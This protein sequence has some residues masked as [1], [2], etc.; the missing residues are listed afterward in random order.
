M[1]KYTL[2]VL[3][4]VA[5]F[6]LAVSV[7]PANAGA[8]TLTYVAPGPTNGELDSMDAAGYATASVQW[9]PSIAYV[10]DTLITATVTWSDTGG[11]D[12]TSSQ[13]LNCSA[14]TIFGAEY[15][16]GSANQPGSDNIYYATF[17]FDTTGNTGADSICLRVPVADA[18]GEEQATANFSLTILVTGDSASGDFGGIEYYSNGG[19]D[20]NVHG[21]IGPTLEFAIVETGDLK[22][23][24]HD[25]QLGEDQSLTNMD[26]SVTNTCA[27]RIKVQTNATDGFIVYV[28]SD[29]PLD[30]SG[31]ATITDVTD[32]E[33]PD[34]STGEAYGFA[35]E[36]A[37]DGGRNPITGLFDQ[38]IVEHDAGT[39]FDF[40]ADYTPVPTNT[41]PQMFSFTD[42]FV[43]SSTSAFTATSLITHAATITPTT[44]SG[45]YDQLVTYTVTPSF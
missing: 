10:T 15:T 33:Y 8:R 1:N 39:I 35:L 30:S 42:G 43:V 32:D 26:Y 19:N 16:F 5:L 2:K 34:P 37:T 24:D 7:M 9:T 22:A 20:V 41:T 11:W 31:Y 12:S 44:P 27:Y 23:E 21:T 29:G 17:T 3:S 4:F 18:A 40:T 13:I 6:A 38:P 45:Y 36:A 28:T 14:A 25:C